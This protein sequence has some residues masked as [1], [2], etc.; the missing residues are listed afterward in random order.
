MSDYEAN[1]YNAPVMFFLGAGASVPLG[2]PTTAGFWKDLKSRP[3]QPQEAHELLLQLEK[4]I[5]DNGVTDIEMILDRLLDW[6]T[7][8]Q[9]FAEHPVSR[10]LTDV[11]ERLADN[12]A[13]QAH[14]AILS[15]VVDTYG[16]VNPNDAASLWNAVFK[17][18][19]NLGIRTLPVFTTNYD[20]VIEQ[21][22]L[23]SEDLQRA[24]AQVAQY[25]NE[26]SGQYNQVAPQGYITLRDGF[27]LGHREF[28]SWDK[29]EFHGYDEDPD[30]LTVVL[31]KMHGSVTWTFVSG[32]DDESQLEGPLEEYGYD[33]GEDSVG[34][35]PP[36]V[37]RDPMGRTTA[38]HYPYLSKPLPDYELI[39]VPYN[40]FLSCLSGCKLCIS[41]GS[42]FRDG[43]I[44]ET[45]VEG[46]MVRKGYA[47][48][49]NQQ[50]QKSWIDPKAP[51]LAMLGTR[52][53]RD[54]LAIMTVAP[55]PDHLMLRKKISARPENPAINVIPVDSEFNSEAANG[56]MDKIQRM[57]PH[58]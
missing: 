53:D 38:I 39:T 40:Y 37:G 35:L 22:V 1:I 9:R 34:L 3:I 16:D 21:A 27:K 7:Q 18:I 12:I 50:G 11:Q 17:G 14:Q 26:E 8:A 45:L 2:L 25:D 51:E 54:D 31:S 47:Y 5:S 28:A 58:D 42:K 32:R 41:I 19:W 20:T 10:K 56:I 48:S 46:A 4:D 30:R 29:W 13:R 15:R 43:R 57:I 44:I 49:T 23:F 33:P 52:E 36:G 55:A 6:E 24:D